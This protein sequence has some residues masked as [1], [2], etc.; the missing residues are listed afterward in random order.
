MP[1]SFEARLELQARMANAEA[2]LFAA[3]RL[4]LQLVGWLS[5][6]HGLAQAVHDYQTTLD[7]CNDQ[8]TG[9]RAF[10]AVNK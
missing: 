3:R 9:L 5:A 2:L 8:L 4:V 1:A 6:H 7:N 10:Y